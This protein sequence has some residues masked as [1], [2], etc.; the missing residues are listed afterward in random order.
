MNKNLLL[1]PGP[2]N[3]AEN[4]RTAISKDDI[5]HREV[6]FDLLLQSVERKILNLFEIQR[7]SEYRAVVI[8]ENRVIMFGV[9]HS[10]SMTR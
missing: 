3:V 4:V 6:E 2:V 8:K 1:T 5:C 10:I 9:N 7:L